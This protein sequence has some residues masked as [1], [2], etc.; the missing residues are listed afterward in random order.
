MNKF[1]EF[2]QLVSFVSISILILVPLSNRQFPK[3]DS[4]PPKKPRAR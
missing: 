3:D 1:I 2:V 4:D